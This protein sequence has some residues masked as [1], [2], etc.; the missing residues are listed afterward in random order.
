MSATAVREKRQITLPEEIC[1]AVGLEIGDQVEWQVEEGSIRGTKLVPQPVEVL[2]SKDVDP[3][4]FL[5]RTG[6]I[7]KESILKGLQESRE[8]GR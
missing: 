6:Q 3:K 1:E 8:R 5:P 2:D 7:T 4:T